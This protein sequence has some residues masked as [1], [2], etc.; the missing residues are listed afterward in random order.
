MAAVDLRKGAKEVAVRER[1]EGG[2]KWQGCGGGLHR[3][4][5][6]GRRR[7]GAKGAREEDPGGWRRNGP[8]G[9]PAS[10]SRGLLLV[11]PH[12]AV[13]SEIRRLRSQGG[14][15]EGRG[16]GGWLGWCEN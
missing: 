15:V 10:G 11:E 7:S 2:E 3:S 16:G 6:G 8:R 5:R 14:C 1:R 12:L 4:R 13:G 9:G